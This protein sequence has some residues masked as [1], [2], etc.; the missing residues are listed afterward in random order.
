VP[1]IHDNEV[2]EKGGIEMRKVS[3]YAKW[4]LVGILSV[5]LSLV[6]TNALANSF[7]FDAVGESALFNY[8]LDVGGGN[9]LTATTQYTVDAISANSIT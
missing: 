7:T 8:S 2:R 5:C 4:V 3:H 1:L 6:S 9:F